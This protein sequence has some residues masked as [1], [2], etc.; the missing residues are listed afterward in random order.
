MLR[1]VQPTFGQMGRDTIDGTTPSRS[2][3]DSL[4]RKDLRRRG[5]R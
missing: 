3:G 2:R 4:R 1:K 5:F